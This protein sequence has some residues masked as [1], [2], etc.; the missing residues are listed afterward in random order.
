MHK[1]NCNWSTA[2]Y[3]KLVR[4]RVQADNIVS[5]LT[6]KDHH[7]NIILEDFKCALKENHSLIWLSHTQQSQGAIQVSL[8]YNDGNEGLT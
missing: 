4:K 1:M 7:S 2:C 8:S 3:I 6:Q 5:A